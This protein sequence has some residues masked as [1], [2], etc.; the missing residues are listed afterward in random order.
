MTAV[1]PFLKRNA[2]WLLLA[3]LVVAIIGGGVFWLSQSGLLAIEVI[4]VEGNSAVPSETVLDIAGPLLMGEGLIMPPLDRAADALEQEPLVA[5]VS[6]ERRFPH[7]IVIRVREH[8]PAAYL[9]GPGGALYLVSSD[10][11]V[12]MPVDAA[13]QTLPV[14]STAEPCDAIEQGEPPGC[15]D[16]VDGVRF[17]VDIPVN[18]VYGFS[19]VDVD[20][21]LIT[22]VTGNGV[23]VNFGDLDQYDLKFEVLRQMLARASMSGVKM[24]IDVS[25]PERPVTRQGD[26]AAAPNPDGNAAADST[27]AGTGSPDAAGE[28]VAAD[29]Q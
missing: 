4:E 27:A 5:D 25:V 1:S 23:S 22:A 2:W 26:E 9:A 18:F 16:A 7:T 3:V 24:T 6:F 19:R 28:G 21:G 17:V 11:T 15:G 10:G 20:G 12:L 13:D 29:G 8:H 14:I